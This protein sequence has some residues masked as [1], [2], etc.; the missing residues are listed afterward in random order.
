MPTGRSSL[1]KILAARVKT[2]IDATVKETLDLSD[3]P[4]DEAKAL[5]RGLVSIC[6]SSISGLPY[7]D[8]SKYITDGTKDNG[9]DGCFYDANKNKLF[10]VQ[11]KWSSAGTKTIEAGDTHKFLQGVY[12][13]LDLNW[14]NFNA[15]FKAIYPEIEAG[16]KNDPHIVIV[17]TYNSDNPISEDCEKLF[18]KFLLENNS[19]DQEVVSYTAFDLTKIIRAIKVSKTGARTD[20]DLGLLDW[21]ENKT[22]YYSIYGRVSC[23]DVAEW[24]KAHGDL[25]FSEN[26]R[27]TLSN[28]DINQKISESATKRPEVFWYLNNG[29]TAICDEFKRKPVGL[30]EQKESSLWTVSNLKI[31]NG[32]QTTSAIAAAY[33]SSPKAIKKAYVQIR[34]IALAKAPLD[35][36]S[37]I[38]TATNTQNRVE[39]RDF[40][41]LD[42]TQDGL[43]ES[44][45]KI[46]IQYCFRRGEIVTN[47]ANGLDVQGLALSLASTSDSMQDVVM[48]KRN[49]G[50]LTD[51]N[52]HYQKI[53]GIHI[54]PVL[55]WKK[56]KLWMKARDVVDKLAGSK[57]D[58]ERQLA[59]H[60][61]RFIENHLVR[62]YPKDI[63]IKT[64][65]KIHEHLSKS[66]EENYKDCYL[67]VLFKN[68]QKCTVLSDSLRRAKI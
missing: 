51:P 30:G 1:S 63:S 65:D 45:K 39:P 41:A 7:K 58:R 8:V 17:V 32:A 38:T 21:G 40:L 20:V 64:A 52:G 5:S 2:H 18:K 56:Y 66:I 47:P 60:G 12:D 13:L 34:V 68:A 37:Q 59:V 44:F 46:G 24:H 14:K 27:Y 9:I 57:R 31:V 33:K 48:A 35:I 3:C 43:S 49:V 15:R 11:S 54:D 42:T 16:L 28:S 19:D 23:A 29:I 25:L 62:F 36:G 4:S 6:L 50:S 10:L 22:P 55:A 53:F 67:A 26:I 61:N